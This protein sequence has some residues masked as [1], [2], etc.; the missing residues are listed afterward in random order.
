MEAEQK[1]KIRIVLD[2]IKRKVKISHIILIILL[3]AG[4]TF[5][6][7]VFSSEVSGTVDVHVRAWKILLKDGDNEIKNYVDVNVAA[8]YPGMPD[9]S[10]EVTV[11]N[12]SEVGA[13]LSYSIIEARVLDET[14]VT[15]EGRYDR[16]DEVLPTDMTSKQ[17]EEKFINDYPF[18]VSYD[19]TKEVMEAEVGESVYS[20]NVTWPYESGDDERDT[21]WG[22]AASY[23]KDKFP[24]KAC[25]YLKIK[26]SVTQDNS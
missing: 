19:M 22:V 16:G 7:F 3:L 6:W 12:E 5:A 21:N 20:V 1:K 23:Y 15:V 2:V 11:Y 10:K 26:V 13:K 25:I 18:R 14:F 8:V 4:N 17:L 24:D 9:F